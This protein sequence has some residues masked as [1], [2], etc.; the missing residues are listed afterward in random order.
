MISVLVVLF[1][2]VAYVFVYSLLYMAKRSKGLTKDIFLMWGE[3]R[4]QEEKETLSFKKNKV[5]KQESVFT[6]PVDCGECKL[7]N[8]CV[9]NMLEYDTDT[10]RGGSGC[11]ELLRKHIE[12]SKNNIT[13]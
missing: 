6:V 10:T 11:V 7:L 1:L 12:L 5:K 3:E 4:K 2:C 9:H 13:N 8:L